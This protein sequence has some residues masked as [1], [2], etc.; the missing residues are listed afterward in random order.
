MD[1]FLDA[2]GLPTYALFTMLPHS[3]SFQFLINWLIVC[4]YRKRGRSRYDKHSDLC[5]A[6][7]MQFLRELDS[8]DWSLVGSVEPQFDHY[9]T[10]VNER[11]SRT[12]AKYE[13][14]SGHPPTFEHFIVFTNSVA[15]NNWG[16]MQCPT[17]TFDDFMTYLM[18]KNA[19]P[20]AWQK[21]FGRYLHFLI[22]M[23]F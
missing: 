21:Q 22:Y 7:Y 14:I 11:R 16:A 8:R 1:H 17:P 23:F 10:F 4:L 18:E 19:S 13:D 12:C 9:A 2:S 15:S 5:L 6:D 20:G 3:E